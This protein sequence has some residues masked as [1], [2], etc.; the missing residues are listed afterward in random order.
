MNHF[1]SYNTV[2]SAVNTFA[3]SNSARILFKL[4]EWT[5]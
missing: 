3:K 2:Q 1:Q 5:N 4:N